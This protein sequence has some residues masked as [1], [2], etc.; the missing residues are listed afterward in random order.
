M[1][2]RQISQEDDEYEKMYYSSF[3]FGSHPDDAWNTKFDTPDNIIYFE[4]CMKKLVNTREARLQRREQLFKTR[5][6]G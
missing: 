2:Q 4:I 3:A 5:D 6:L 1:P